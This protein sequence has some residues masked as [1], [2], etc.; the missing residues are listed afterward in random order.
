MVC[1]KCRT[2]CLIDCL[3]CSRRHQVGPGQITNLIYM[4]LKHSQIF[5]FFLMIN[6]AIPTISDPSFVG[7]LS[8]CHQVLPWLHPVTPHSLH[9]ISPSVQ[10]GGTPHLSFW[11]VGVCTSKVVFTQVQDKSV[12]QW[13]EV[14]RICLVKIQKDQNVVFKLN[15]A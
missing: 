4:A 8:H 7:L 14:G 11:R 5:I 3:T 6:I 9:S 12:R 15:K 1:S 2:F 10:P 13:K